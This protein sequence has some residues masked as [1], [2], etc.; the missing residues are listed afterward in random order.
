MRRFFKRPLNVISFSVFLLLLIM[1]FFPQL[2]TSYDPYEM[3]V[4]EMLLPPSLKHIFGTDQ[5]GRDLFSRVIHGLKKSILVAFLS[6]VIAC[7][8]GTIIGTTS[9]YFGGK[10]DI[11]IMRIIDAFFSFPPLILALFIVALFGT[12]MFKLIMS[13]SVV[14]T[15]IFARTI[16]SFTLPLRE[17]NYVIAAK[18][19]GRRD[20]AIL[21]LHVLPNVL[22]MILITFAM[23]FSTA[24]LTEA[25]LGFLGFGVPPPEPSLG[26]LIGEG[27]NYFLGAPWVMIYPGLVVAV[28]V[29]SVN[30]ISDSLQ[31]IMN[32]RR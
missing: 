2:F 5:F 15:P 1:G 14:Y 16:R 20:G 29:L 21:I 19:I 17:T 3:N 28:M 30:M 27:R 8:I 9:A 18:A 7:A 10:Y 4:E 12:G 22:P 25:T 6:M 32:P 26:G 31:E 11:L 24:F 13:I 23:N